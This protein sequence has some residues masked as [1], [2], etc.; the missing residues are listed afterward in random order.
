M[1]TTLR[2]RFGTRK[3]V[4]PGRE[5]CKCVTTAEKLPPIALFEC[6]Q[7]TSSITN[8]IKIVSII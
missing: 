8:T 4:V 7:A 2:T 5:G 6:Y 3:I 1:E